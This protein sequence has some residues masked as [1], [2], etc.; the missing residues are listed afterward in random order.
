M[1]TAGDRETSRTPRDGE[2]AVRVNIRSNG[3]LT[4]D[5][6]TG[7]VY[8]PLAGDGGR[9]VA[10][11]ERDGRITMLP[12]GMAGAHLAVSGDH[13]WQMASYAG[14]QLSRTSLSS[15]DR[16]EVLG[17]EQDHHPRFKLLDR[18][19]KAL[20]AAEAER[21]REDWRGAQFTVRDDGVPILLSRSGRLFEV[22]GR[23]VLKRWEPPG[24]E[25]ALRELGGAEHFHATDLTADGAQE[26]VVL[27]EAGLLRVGSDGAVQATRFPASARQAPPWTAAVPLSG[28]D[29]LLLGGV[30]PLQGKPRP[31]LV[32]R[33]GELQMLSLGA[34]KNCDEFDGS[35]A[36]VA[37]ADPGGVAEVPGGSYVLSD[38]NCGR[39][40]RFR[41]PENLSYRG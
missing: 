9:Q 13:L 24:Y 20:P 12:I 5:R 40:Y 18:S 19:G 8:V 27:G 15:L 11:I 39:V 41:L 6:R 22:A 38:K 23:D 1:I 35:M 14:L 30:S 32:T 17:S 4:A 26:V 21:L 25:A 7:E 29:V 36:D 33:H 2:Y 10:K 28:G 37:S 34:Q 16:T 31:A 3:G